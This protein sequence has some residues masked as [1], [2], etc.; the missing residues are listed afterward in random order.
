MLYRYKTLGVL[1][2][3][4][5]ERIMTNPT[6]IQGHQFVLQP[7]RART[8]NPATPSHARILLQPVLP[9]QFIQSGRPWE[10]SRGITGRKERLG[11]KNL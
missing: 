3:F 1:K 5:L 10:D 2:Y 8:G 6:T 9:G 7:A 4:L 11:V